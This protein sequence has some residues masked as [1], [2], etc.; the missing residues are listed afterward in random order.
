MEPAASTSTSHILRDSSPLTPESDLEARPAPHPKQQKDIKK[1]KKKS[2]HPSSARRQSSSAAAAA[3]KRKL[4]YTPRSKKYNKD[5]AAWLSPTS[6]RKGKRPVSDDSDDHYS[7]HEVFISTMVI[8][9]D[10]TG[11]VQLPTFVSAI[12][13][14]SDN[15]DEDDITTS[16][17]DSFDSDSSIRP[18]EEELIISEVERAKVRYEL[19]KTDD[20]WH[21]DKRKWD[22]LKNSNN[23]EIR[24]RKRSVGPD[25]SGTD[26]TSESGSEM[27][28][29]EEEEEEGEADEE[30]DPDIEYG[31]GLVTGW[32]ISDDED[33]DAEL[34]FATLTDDS[35]GL[36]SDADIEDEDSGDETDNSDLSSI[37]MREAVAAGLLLPSLDAGCPLVVTED[38]DGRLVFTN[39]LRDGQGVL[40]VH[41]EVSA[42]QRQRSIRDAM[43]VQVATGSSLPSA[44]NDQ[45]EEEEDEEEE[46]TSDDGET[47]DDVLDQE[48]P[49]VVALP[50]RFPTPPIASIDPLSTLSPIVQSKRPKYHAPAPINFNSPKPADILAGKVYSESSSVRSQ[51]SRSVSVDAP[52]VPGTSASASSHQ[53]R[54]PRMGSFVTVSG[55]PQRRAIIDGTVS[56]PLS[57]FPRTRRVGRGRER[58][59]IM[60]GND[61]PHPLKRTRQASLPSDSRTSTAAETDDPVVQS[62]PELPLPTS[63][64][65]DDVL[66][67][68]FLDSDDSAFT[69][70]TTLDTHL[71]SLTR[72]DRVPVSTFRRSRTTDLGMLTIVA[73]PS[74]GV[75]YGSTGGHVYRRSPGSV[76][77]WLRDKPPETQ[78]PGSVA[79]SPVIFPVRAGEKL[80]S[81]MEEFFQDATS[82]NHTGGSNNGVSGGGAKS[83]KQK[84]KEKKKRIQMAK[85]RAQAEAAATS[86]ASA[87]FS[88]FSSLP[89]VVPPLNL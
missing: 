58:K 84:R 72:W 6:R 57:P 76:P 42:A 81:S 36:G 78:T 28:I 67:A 53:S 54:Q 29:D 2:T 24:P 32:R 21:M 33:F 68:S 22:H 89:A 9:S 11:K 30:D 39:G 64:G 52:S 86:T 35:S 7:D 79:V 15:D 38:W 26:S 48:T 60:V 65:L 87:A 27:D 18:E 13:G 49:H 5:A 45:E 41:F 40:D 25:D 43:E 20:S 88:A 51:R 46:L 55:D 69:T 31:R 34:F 50:L 4:S 44:E 12:S 10:D 66:D 19:F 63:I 37:S 16:I 77:L 23:W 71:R 70:V 85:A 17:A 75:S 59:R 83:H 61:I 74:D 8:D 14:T 56:S 73:P 3:P 47:T 1:P 80:A 82:E 62:S